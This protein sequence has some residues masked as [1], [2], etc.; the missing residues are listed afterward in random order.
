MKF[1]ALAV[2]AVCVCLPEI[3][4]KSTKG[5]K[6]GWKKNGNF[7][8]PGKKNG[9]SKNWKSNIH[10]PKP[11]WDND[12]HKPKIGQFNGDTTK[13]CGTGW[14]HANSC[15]QQLC[16]NG[17]NDECTVAGETCFSDMT[18]QCV[19]GD[20]TKRC[21]TGW[22]QAN[23]CNQ[24]L[25]PN[26]TND[27]CTVAGETCFSDMTVQ[28]DT[29][30][31][32]SGDTT[33]RCGTG[34]SEANSCSQQLCPNG[35]DEECT[36]AGESCFSDMTVQCDTTPPVSGDTTKRCGTGWTQANSCSQQLCPNG[37]NDECTVAG[38]TCFSDMT[39]QCDTTPPVSGDTTKRCGTGWPQANSCSQQLC[40]NGTNE[41]CT[42]AGETCFSD[43]TVQCD[44]S[45]P[46]SGDTTKRCGTGWTQANSC[47]QTLCPSGTDEE[48]GAGESCYADLPPCD[49]T[50][51]P[52]G[53]AP[54]YDRCVNPN[55]FA[56]TFDDGPTAPTAALL[57]IL[58][59]KGVPATFFV[60]GINLIEGQTGSIN[61][62]IRM[63]NDGH[64]IASHTYNHPDLALK[65]I[66]EVTSEMV[67]THNRIKVIL[68]SP[69]LITYMR[70]PYGSY[71]D[72]VRETLGSLNYKVIMW[73]WD[74]L[75]WQKTNSQQIVDA[76]TSWIATPD[77]I[78]VGHCTLQ[79]DIHQKTV[80]AMAA[81]ID[82]IL[83]SGKTFVRVDECLGLPRDNV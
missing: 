19:S 45:P 56:L 44:T 61:S 32:I 37:T 68:N 74:S 64:Q 48:C 25:C 55:H 51:D 34:W 4:A 80:G 42:V 70:P 81:V 79:H 5:V 6:Q 27:E 62:L 24:Q 22:T 72:A 82:A 29:T 54:I 33:K 35:T 46:V 75:D 21:G 40:P 41:E 3:E 83:A 57:D 17:T 15:S 20:T 63:K 12:S 28:C 9:H 58:A 59:A 31:P 23:S 66:A 52:E 69:E 7:Q 18:V 30:P 14:T 1:A 11:T 71:N 49:S 36:V 77:F 53:F 26:G 38:E 10:A 73:S 76:Y 50:P 13:R 16:P 60:C 65:S 78:N 8:N 2:M 39:V 43:M 47:G 67:D